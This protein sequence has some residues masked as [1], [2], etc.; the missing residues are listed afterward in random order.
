MPT[1]LHIRG[2]DDPPSGVLRTAP[3]DLVDQGS[4]LTQSELIITPVAV[5]LTGVQRQVVAEDLRISEF[6]DA[7]VV[8][9]E[10]TNE[11]GHT[12]N[13]VALTL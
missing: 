10:Q 6:N 5:A 3:L 2:F 11:D 13:L 7:V 8:R 4:P 12:P 1:E 9:T